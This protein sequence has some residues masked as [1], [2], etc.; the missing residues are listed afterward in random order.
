M[1]VNSVQIHLQTSMKMEIMAGKI[2]K[3]I[4]NYKI[5]RFIACYISAIHKETLNW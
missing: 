2:I 4:L 5:N 3:I 1:R